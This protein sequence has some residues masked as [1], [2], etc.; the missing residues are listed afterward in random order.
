MNYITVAKNNGFEVVV[1]DVDKFSFATKTITLAGDNSPSKWLFLAKTFFPMK[2]G[3]S[4]R[5]KN[6][7]TELENE[8]TTTL[9]DDVITL[10]NDYAPL[11]QVNEPLS[12]DVGFLTDNEPVLPNDVP[13]VPEINDIPYV[14]SFAS[15]I[16]KPANT[17][18][19]TKANSADKKLA[20]VG[21]IILANKESTL[22]QVVDLIAN[23]EMYDP[24][25]KGMIGWRVNNLIDV[26]GWEDIAFHKPKVIKGLAT[27]ESYILDNVGLTFKQYFDNLK[28]YEEFASKADKG[29]ITL[30]KNV[31]FKHQIT[32]DKGDTVKPETHKKV[33]AAKR[34]KIKRDEIAYAKPLTDLITALVADE[35]PIIISITPTESLTEK[36]L[37]YNV[38]YKE[39]INDDDLD[40]LVR[41]VYVNVSL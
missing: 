7:A 14:P 17:E 33:A 8:Y 34:T 29:L 15:L 2:E 22:E 27:V 19:E 20:A 21:D 23:T 13:D 36:G 5:V 37:V 35:C 10:P 16:P 30:I 40:I 11:P 6:K 25:A 32:F 4:Q 24:N 1:S 39:N 38:N 3:N 28:Q 26:M 12:D 18:P 9:S 41:E 31:A